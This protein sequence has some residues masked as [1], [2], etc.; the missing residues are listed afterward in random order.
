MD[1][2]ESSFTLGDPHPHAPSLSQAAPEPDSVGEEA[3]FPLSSVHL[4]APIIDEP[5]A[6]GGLKQ[7]QINARLAEW[8]L[9]HGPEE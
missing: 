7:T 8:G 5:L 3:M 4:S 2:Y 9:T 1:G 6:R